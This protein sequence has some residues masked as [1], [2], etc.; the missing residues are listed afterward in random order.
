MW[1]VRLIFFLLLLAL[2]VYFFAANAGQTVDLRFF[3]RELLAIELFWVVA[4]SFGLGLLVAGSGWLAREWRHR[5]EAGRLRR[6]NAGL[7]KEL[8]E[9]RTLPL[10]ELTEHSASKDH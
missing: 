4:A 1:M 7:E 2:L 10:R 8:G 9:L 5:R 3:G 6:Q